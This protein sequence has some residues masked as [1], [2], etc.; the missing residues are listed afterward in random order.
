MSSI[1]EIPITNWAGPFGAE[2]QKKAV[3]ALEDDSVLFF[4]SL[5]FKLDDNEK[6][7]LDPKLVD[8]SKAVSYNPE[9]RRMVHCAA[10]EA[11]K[12]AVAAMIHRFCDYSQGLIEGLLPQYKGKLTPAG[13]TLRP[14]EA[15]G[16]HQEWRKD[17]TRLHVD[18][19][20]TTPLNGKRIL[21]LF[22]NV[23]R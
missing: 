12:P 1:T 10:S 8:D 11:D 9:T 22:S 2:L 23:D 18:A 14:V 20:P 19:F 13:A 7:F 17:D 16:R 4:S 15:E 6:R 21:R 3:T 5:A